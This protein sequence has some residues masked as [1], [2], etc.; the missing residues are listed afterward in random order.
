[1]IPSGPEQAAVLVMLLDEAQASRVLAQL[2]AEEL[3]VLGESMC[4]LGEIEP[5]AIS[6]AIAGFVTHAQHQGLP[7]EDRSQ[8]VRALLGSAVGAVK[9]DSLMQRIAPAQA[10]PR[11]LELAQW[12]NPDALL[13]LV[14]DE[15]PQAI[16]LLLL[17]LDPA[18][19]AEVLFGLPPAIQP[20]VV[21]RVA[22]MGP[23]AAQGLTMLEDLLAQRIT[24]CHGAAP[25]AQGGP[26]EAA[27][28]INLAGKAME[29]R[30]MPEMAKRDRQ[31]AK[32]I[33][34]EM[35]KFE[36]LFVLDP[37]A[38]GVLLR[39]IESEVLIDALKGIS[40]E[41]R[42]CFFAAMS[43]RAADGV[44]DEIANRGRLKLADVTE[45]QR[46]I[47]AAARRLSG[48]GLLS[49]GNSDADD[50]V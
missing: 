33:E 38:M 13:R 41:E 21:H 6:R 48:E 30:V 34:Y 27:G 25:L 39:E 50:Y 46:T 14:E 19:A 12:L 7:A 17:Q 26:R 8:R 20:D 47:V 23:V 11:A 36:H 24:Q 10:A 22:T 15:H 4:A 2:G 29:K 28:M 18:V 1:M 3:R 45:A 9:A 16:A 49:F 42:D 32:A 5:Q 44:R 40:E 43:S 37:Q 35:F 31:L